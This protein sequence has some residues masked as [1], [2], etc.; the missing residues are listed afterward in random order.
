MNIHPTDP[1]GAPAPPDVR[2]T[3]EIMK[4]LFHGR[5]IAPTT[6]LRTWSR[7]VLNSKRKKRKLFR[8]AD[9]V[10]KLRILTAAAR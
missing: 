6:S 8:Y 10:K 4:C 1:A 2:S 9:A 5:T 7:A 3:T